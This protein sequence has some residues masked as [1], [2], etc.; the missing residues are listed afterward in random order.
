MYQRRGFPGHPALLR[1]RHELLGRSVDKIHR[2]DVMGEG[3][4]KAP[5]RAEPHPT[6]SLY[7]RRVFP[8]GPACEHR[9]AERVSAYLLN[10]RLSFL[11]HFG[12]YARRQKAPGWTM[13]QPLLA[14]LKRLL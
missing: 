2:G 6:R 8:R 7:L 13:T 3:T 11:G 12:P 10:P 9:F 1:D 4:R 14:G 5:V